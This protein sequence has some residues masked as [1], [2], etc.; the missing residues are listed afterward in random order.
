MW[1]IAIVIFQEWGGEGDFLLPYLM[2]HKSW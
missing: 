1:K 2:L